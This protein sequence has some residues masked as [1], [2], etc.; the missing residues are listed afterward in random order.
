LLPGVT[1]IKSKYYN[2]SGGRGY[3]SFE[4]LDSL[5]RTIEKSSYQ[6]ERLLARTWYQYN[7]Q[8]DLIYEISI[9]DI[10][11]PNEVDTTKY[12]YV[13]NGNRIE[14][15]KCIYRNND[16]VI[17]KLLKNEGDSI[18]TYQSISYNYLEDKKINNKVE[19]THILTYQN[20]LLTQLEFIDTDNSKT[21][22]IYTYFENGRLKRRVIQRIPEPPYKIAYAGGPGSDDQS[23]KYI[24]NKAGRVKK[25]YTI[26]ENKT[27]KLA[28]YNYRNN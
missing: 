22:T 25:E 4:K 16:S 1:F 6:K 7:N 2:G 19:N 12:E 10:N 23:F 15:Q 13:Y 3:W 9:Y 17:Y 21:I 24:D 27:Y 5:G 26:V 11:K 20:N 18:L 28:K 14:F 8:D